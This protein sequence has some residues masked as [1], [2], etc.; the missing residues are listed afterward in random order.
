MIVIPDKSED[1]AIV[2]V[3]L[4]YWLVGWLVGLDNSKVVNE[5]G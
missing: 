1:S 3:G 4:A 5:L 2:S